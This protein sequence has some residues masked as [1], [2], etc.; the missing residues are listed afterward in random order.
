MVMFILPQLGGYR[1]GQID[2]GLITYLQDH[3]GLSRYFSIGP[4][5]ANFPADD[6][7]AGLNA[8]QVPDPKNWHQYFET[9]LISTPN[10]AFYGVPIARELPEFLAHLPAFAGA[11][12]KYIG[13]VP[14][15]DGLAGT[16]GLRLVFKNDTVNLY[17]LAAAA[18]YA[19]TDSGCGLVVLNRQEMRSDCKAP[20][21]LTRRELFYPG[22]HAVVNGAAMPVEPDGIFQRI[23][24]PAGPVTVRFW[25]MPEG[26]VTSC[27]IA[28]LAALAWGFCG[29]RWMG[30]R[31]T[32]TE[33]W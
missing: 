31:E 10:N 12:A 22:W 27:A 9:Q 18:P 33:I 25:Y 15:Q 24:L 21:V 28:I 13:I 1:T 20:S 5:A 19:E 4:W 7:V 16:P 14:A 8:L 3:A 23:N 2:R 32:V 29:W 6:G 17:E 30:R 26:T 11:G